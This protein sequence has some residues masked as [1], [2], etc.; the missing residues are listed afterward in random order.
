MTASAGANWRERPARRPA[1]EGWL[2]GG[3]A[4]DRITP[5]ELDALGQLP[6]AVVLQ[7]SGV[8]VGADDQPNATIPHR[9]ILISTDDPPTFHYAGSIDYDDRPA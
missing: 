7:Q 8:Y 1:T 3:P 9:Y 2:L 4:D 5:I 6:A